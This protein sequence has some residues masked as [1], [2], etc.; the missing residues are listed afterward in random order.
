M[1]GIGC[2]LWTWCYG[3]DFTLLQ[4]HYV[5]Q[6]ALSLFYQNT[7]GVIFILRNCRATLQHSPFL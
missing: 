4:V 6:C 1:D 2:A 7:K 5:P 3:R